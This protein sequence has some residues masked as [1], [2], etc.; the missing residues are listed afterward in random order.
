MKILEGSIL[1]FNGDFKPNNVPPKEEGY[2]MTIR[3]GLSGI[4]YHLD[5]YKNNNWLVRILDASKVIAYSKEQVP[6]ELVDEWSNAI[7]KR[8]KK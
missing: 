6:K 1:D 4:Y 2:Y 3:C 5:E 7:L 8:H